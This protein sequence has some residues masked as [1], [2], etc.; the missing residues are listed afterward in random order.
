MMN[1]TAKIA[2]ALR[3]WAVG[4]SEGKSRREVEREG[5]VSVPVVPLD[6]IARR[7]ADDR[8]YPAAAVENFSQDIISLAGRQ[9]P[10]ALF[11]RTARQFP[12]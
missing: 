4:S 5:R 10:R 11:K 12:P 9:S 3:S 1:P 7:T 2:A 8:L 6:Q